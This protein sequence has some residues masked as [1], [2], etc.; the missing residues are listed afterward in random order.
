MFRKEIRDNLN[1]FIIPEK[2]FHPSVFSFMTNKIFDQNLT[3]KH[4]STSNKLVI[5][6]LEDL[7][8]EVYEIVGEFA[9]GRIDLHIDNHNKLRIIEDCKK[10]KFTQ[11]GKYKVDRV[12]TTDGFKFFFDSDTWLMIRPSGTEPVL[13]T[14]AEANTQD[15][16]FDILAACKSTIL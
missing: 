4:T 8:A 11:F 7:I 1:L 6:A 16:A 10:G 5:P 2:I 3:F 14:Y 9:F 15:K 13:R 12:E